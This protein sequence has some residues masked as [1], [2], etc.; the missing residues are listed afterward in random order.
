MLF[1]FTYITAKYVAQSKLKNKKRI[2]ILGGGPSG[3][4]MF[5]RLVDAGRTDITIDVFEKKQELGTGMPYSTE[6]AGTE[7]ITNV[8]GNEIPELVT[9]VAEWI[10]TAPKELLNRFAITPKIYNDYKVLPRLLFGQYLA[11]QFLLLQ[12]KADEAGIT[13]TIHYNS[14]VTDIIDLPEQNLIRVKIA[15][16]RSFEFEQAIICTGHK[17]SVKHEGKVPGWFDSPYPPVK[18]SLQLDHAVAIKGASLTA[19]DAIRTLARQNGV[20]YKNKAGKLIYQLSPN[21]E[22]FK[23]VMH[24]RHGMLPAVRFHLEDSHL[25]NDSL[26]TD[27][28]I[29]AHIKGNNGFL[30]LDLFL[31]RILKNPSAKNNPC[32]TN[33]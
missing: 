24:S 20:Y 31:S 5:K 3:L 21:S 2:A 29:A 1:R 12:Q 7:H 16:D 14:P 6:G 23:M 25:R 17:W 32:F 19:V 15:G 8:S 28:E 33:I 18:L 22:G 11:A 27:E 4:F 30:S 9:S 10:E 13:Y 26:L